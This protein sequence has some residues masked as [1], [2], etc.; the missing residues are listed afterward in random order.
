MVDTN[1]EAPAA[2]AF[3]VP[4]QL[5]AARLV[6]SIVVFVLIIYDYYLSAMVVFIVAAS[7]DWIDGY[8]ARRFNRKSKCVMTYS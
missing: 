4:N 1:Q 5:T 8:W 3:N 2:K 7:T 6:L